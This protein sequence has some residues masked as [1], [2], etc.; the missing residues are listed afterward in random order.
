[1]KRSACDD[2]ATE[3]PK[4]QI[5][6]GTKYF[7]SPSHSFNTFFLQICVLGRLCTNNQVKKAGPYLIGLRLGNSPVRSITQCLA[8]KSGT[9]NFYTLKVQ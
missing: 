3:A 9:N 2:E 8:K 5:L 7:D 1:M 6:N 4:K